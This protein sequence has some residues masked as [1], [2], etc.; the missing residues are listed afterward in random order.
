[1]KAEGANQRWAKSWSPANSHLEPEP[2]AIFLFRWGPSSSWLAGKSRWIPLPNLRQ[3]PR[4][5]RSCGAPRCDS[6][7]TSRVRWT[8]RLRLPRGFPSAPMYRESH[9]GRTVSILKVNA[10]AVTYTTYQFKC[11]VCSCQDICDLQPF[12]SFDTLCPTLV[13]PNGN[14]V[15]LDRKDS[16]MQRGARRLRQTHA[17]HQTLC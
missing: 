16:E 4:A 9:R 11:D 15:G 5:A 13:R 7:S 10:R 17:D 2:Y 3:M 12:H 8:S 1:M 6:A 14:S